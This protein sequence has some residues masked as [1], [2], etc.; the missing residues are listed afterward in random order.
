L[1]CWRC[2]T[3]IWNRL[4]QADKYHVPRV[5]FINK[6]DRV[7]PILSYIQ[8]MKEDWAPAVPINPFQKVFL[9]VIIDLRIWKETFGATYDGNGNPQI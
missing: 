6:M 5:A 9:C 7:V 4:R 1:R 8:M 2:W 3:A